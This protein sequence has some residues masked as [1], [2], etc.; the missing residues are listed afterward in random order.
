MAALDG[1]GGHG[2]PTL[3][4]R[5]QPP[6]D[7]VNAHP[8]PY[9]YLE[10]FTVALEWL[11]SRY[12]ELLSDEER[13]FIADFARLPIESAAL[14]VRMIMRQGDLFRTSKLN[15]AEIGCPR[16]A[17]VPL[18]ERGWLDPHP[19]VS[20]PNLCRLLRK[21]ELWSALGLRGAA[22]SVRKAELIPLVGEIAEE[23]RPLDAWWPQA[24]DAIFHVRIAPLCDR[25]RL[26]FFGNFHQT[27]SEFVLADL[28]I[29]RYEKIHLD[30]TARAFQTRRQVEQFHAIY[31][32]RE[33]LRAGTALE[34]VLAAMP[35]PL[36]DSAG[37]EASHGESA[38]PNAAV[39]AGGNAWIEAKRAKL[40]FAIAQLHE[41][42]QQL[43]EALD[44]YRN[45]QHPEARIRT[46]RVLEK[47]ERLAEAAALLAQVHQ[48]PASELE[49][50]LSARILP[51]L[52][53]KL[54]MAEQRR[55]PQAR[56][57]LRSWT[58]LELEL[59]YPDP[60]Q[61]VE[62]VVSA[63]LSTPQAPV[64]YVENTL[65][66]SLFG[67]LC[68]S[69]IFTPL[70]GAFFHE[71]HAAPADLLEADFRQ[72]RSAAF[73]ACLSQLDSGIYRDSILRTFEAKAGIQSPF[74]PW[75]ALTR[76]ELELA[77]DCIPPAHLQKFFERLLADV[78]A[79][80]SGLP[81]LIQLWRDEHRYRLIEVKGPG[82]RLQDNQI[83]WLNF[84][85]AQD[86]PV[87]VCKVKWQAVPS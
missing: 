87:A 51:R 15:Y 23:T 86:I 9:Y 65:L 37:R 41:K 21:A 7:T 48:A 28:G 40:L 18:I 77:L 6:D 16:Q 5:P 49:A 19:D 10:N 46:I 73:A 27:W 83:R 55:P 33:L 58:D 76:Q 85:L 59:P 71:F 43:P 34:D 82:D 78:R 12:R 61:R 39:I 38:A 52:N 8:R 54:G 22:R 53:R 45:C 72:R 44:I 1:H 47:L 30:E 13:G 20:F 67:L 70:P 80:R 79:N 36:S 64:L 69:A 14:V 25:L 50:Q 24:P 56:T 31:R 3:A 42:S 17:A 63:H 66:N 26:M 2:S 81:D 57:P 35:P 11:R 29:F 75:G 60:P 4:I 62:L 84:C 74:V 68:W 32:C